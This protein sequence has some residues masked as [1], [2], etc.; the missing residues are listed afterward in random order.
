[1]SRRRKGAKRN[2]VGMFGVVA[3][4]A[5]AIVF[6]PCAG[7][8]D[9]SNITFRS[10]QVV[11]LPCF[12]FSTIYWVELTGTITQLDMIKQSFSVRLVDEDD[13]SAD[14]LLVD[15]T[16]SADPKNPWQKGNVKTFRVNFTLTCQTAT[17]CDNVTGVGG[18]AVHI[19]AV[20]R[21]D[22][23]KVTVADL[24][25]AGG[26]EADLA[27]EISGGPADS[28]DNQYDS[29]SG[30]PSLV[31]CPG[32]GVQPD[33]Y[34]VATDAPWPPFEWSDAAGNLLGFDLDLMR[35]IG[36]LQGF[37]IEILN[38]SWVVIFDYVGTGRVDIGASAVPITEEHELKVDFSDPYWLSDQETNLGFFVAEGDPN[39]LLPLLN[40]GLAQLQELG[41]YDSLVMAYM[42]TDLE[43]VE[44]AW[45]ESIGLLNNGDII[46]FAQ[47]LATLANP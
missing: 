45:Q 33:S 39:G 46:G 27:L 26:D 31:E 43:V 41:V 7:G 24:G 34:R 36:A 21:A 30:E 37:E 2:R 38:C 12:P 15:L 44:M 17:S 4:V 5:A 18:S 11:G 42:G 32:P 9:T 22:N 35:R 29:T 28:D 40:D 8:F 14:E 16:I 19:T 10:T 23:I 3:G 47:S 20:G 13:W 1:M 25:S 6:A